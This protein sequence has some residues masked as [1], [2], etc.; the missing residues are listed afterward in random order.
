MN[1]LVISINI[2][3]NEAH[4]TPGGGSKETQ[5]KTENRNI[6]S[7]FQVGTASVIPVNQFRSLK[8]TPFISPK[9][10]K[11]Q[12]KNEFRGQNVCFVQTLIKPMRIQNSPH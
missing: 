7:P 12:T 10:T 9:L 8:N 6:Q 11:K 3:V 5:H 2:S 1:F 4:T